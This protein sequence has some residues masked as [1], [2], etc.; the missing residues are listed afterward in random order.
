MKFIPN[1]ENEYSVTEDG[2]VF[3]HKSNKFLQVRPTTT[4]PYLYA[5]LCKGGVRK[6]YA[7]HRLVAIT[8]LPNP[9]GY[10]EV[11]HIDRN[12]LNNHVDNLRWASRQM[13][14]TNTDEGF[15]R[16]LRG[17]K[18]YYQNEFVKAFDCVTSAA[19]Y[20]VEQFGASMSSMKKWYR[21]RGCEL[22]M[23]ND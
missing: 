16:N 7:V 19:K 21:S 13:N 3:S 20:A 23:C 11:D 8:Y 6:H 4:S 12:P 9:N 14:L 5:D 17:C 18:L 15:R 10:K 1:Y 2:G 22:V